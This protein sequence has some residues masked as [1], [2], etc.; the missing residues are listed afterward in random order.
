MIESSE[1]LNN[2]AIELAAKGEYKE[3]IACFIRAI[4]LENQNYLLWYN[5]GLTYRDSGDLEAAKAAIEKAL[6]INPEDEEIIETTATLAF[7]LGNLTDAMRY[8]LWG[9]DVNPF[10]SH[11]WNM[12]GVVY[13]NQD[14]Y[15]SASEAFEQALTINPY[16]YDAIY[17]LRDTYIELGN[18]LG[19]QE[20]DAKLKNLS[21]R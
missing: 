7:T 17:N 11:F 2:Q 20:C 5:L 19:A 15:G 8:A 18:P 6:A 21:G 14:D 13:F 10:N 16:Y 9:L 1:K 3:A 12:V 4:S